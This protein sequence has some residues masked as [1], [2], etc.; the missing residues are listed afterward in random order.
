MESRE[1][2]LLNEFTRH[3]YDSTI[4]VPLTV[5]E[6]VDLDSD[7]GIRGG[8]R[9]P[10][11]LGKRKNGEF[12]SENISPHDVIDERGGEFGSDNISTH[13]VKDERAVEVEE[14]V[15]VEW[16][17]EAAMAR[18][19]VAMT[20]QEDA[21]SD[22]LVEVIM[23]RLREKNVDILLSPD[24]SKNDELLSEIVD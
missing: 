23:Q 4:Y 15:E 17:G 9:F 11:N 2:E 6:V 18:G 22:D 13:D 5:D 12:G 20:A 1:A 8:K 10:G 3:Y 16:D 7:G 19:D 21:G 24:I 14:D